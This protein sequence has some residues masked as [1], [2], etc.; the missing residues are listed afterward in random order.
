[1][2]LPRTIL[3]TDSTGGARPIR[4]R[5]CL[6]LAAF[7]LAGCGGGADTG[8]SQAIVHDSAGVRIVT[9]PAS[10]APPR[11]TTDV[12]GRLELPGDFFQVTG[13]VVHDDGTIVVAEA[14]SRTLR[15]FS[16]EGEPRE[17][18]GGPGEGPGE[19]QGISFAAPYPGDSLLVFDLN[20]RRLSIFGADGRFGRSFQLQA[21]EAAPFGNVRGVHRDGSLIATGFSQTPPG[22][23]EDGRHWYTAPI[24]LHG[25][26]GVYRSS[27]PA[28]AG[29]ESYFERFDG[30]GF[31]VFQP[32]FGR[33]TSVIAGPGILVVAS[34]DRWDLRFFTP[35]GTLTHRVR[36]GD[37]PPPPV[38]DAL[39]RAAVNR[40]L[41]AST[42]T[43]DPADLRR[44]HEGMEVPPTLPAHARVAVDR[45]DHVWVER[46]APAPEPQS[47]WLVFAPDGALV[48]Q[49][50]LPSRFMPHFIGEGYL[51]GVLRDELDVEQV[52]RIGLQR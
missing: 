23:P 43:R 41:E 16:P 21:S 24:F 42:S 39:R 13:S 7:L 48:A 45:L 31:T 52:V 29:G 37:G 2:P 33:N 17:T 8:D 10:P 3:A 51:L 38:T 14:G 15:R 26:D 49:V 6:H 12:P 47:E 5:A 25:P 1:M 30:G 40:A 36:L 34:N 46:Y 35:D 27:L 11:W 19:F 44:I 32:L 22:G 18:V 4:S 9:H 28:E 20:L 50:E